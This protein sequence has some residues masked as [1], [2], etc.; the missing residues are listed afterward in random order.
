MVVAHSLRGAIHAL[1]PDDFAL[2][3]RAL[4]ADD[5]DELGGQLGR[6]VIRLFAPRRSVRNGR[7]SHGRKDIL[8][9]TPRHIAVAALLSAAV[10][11]AGEPSAEDGGDGEWVGTIVAE[12]DVTTVVNEA[13]SVWGGTATLIEEA[14]IGVDAGADEYMLGEVWG[15]FAT[16]DYI[17][18]VDRQVPA[19]RAYDLEGNHVRDLGREGQGPGEYTSPSLITVDDGGR[20]FVLDSRA[21]RF[22]VFSPE[23]D[24][25]GTWPARDAMCCAYPMVP[26]ANGNLWA[27]RRFR[28]GEAEDRPTPYAL[29]QF[30]PDGEVGEVRWPDVPSFEPVEIM[31]ETR[32]AGTRPAPVPFSPDSTW[33]TMRS[34]SIVVGASDRYRFEIQAGDGARTVIERFWQ[35]VPVTTE[36]ADWH[37]RYFVTL[38]RWET[39]AEDWSWNGAEMPA[40]K[41]A[42]S[43]FIPAVSGEVWV[44]RPGPGELQAACV[45]N[46]IQAGP[47]E[48]S[49][50]P[51]WHDR[52]IIDAF[53]ADGRYLGDIDVPAGLRPFPAV[54]SINGDH[55]VG[56]V[57]DDLGI[58]R[59]KRWRLVLPG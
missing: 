51:C 54:V 38:A 19:I 31:V 15:V 17:Y 32:F 59:V 47:E 10:A 23:G 33:A 16:D 55:V 25:L 7:V 36:E 49:R 44:R 30:G 35:P 42:F 56:V 52:T 24:D 3:G 1:A 40:S 5:E 2:Y 58:V 37:T 4:I 21:R 43:G 48:A 50:A 45:E 29:Q 46:P 6:P 12:G 41:P 22:N 28:G 14:S 53:G 26:A 27:R 20:V 18:V 39:V 13:G 57:E 11:C 8:M 9:I 34:G